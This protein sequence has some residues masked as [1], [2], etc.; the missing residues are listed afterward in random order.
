MRQRLVL[1]GASFG[2]G[3]KTENH[4]APMSALLFKHNIE[5]FFIV[6]DTKKKCENF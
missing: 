1:R 2:H 5:F 4:S 6:N 3:L